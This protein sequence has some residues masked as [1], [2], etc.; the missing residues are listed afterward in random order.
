[1][2]TP[3]RCLLAALLLIASGAQ[4]ETPQLGRPLTA[5]QLA[6]LPRSVFPDG[7]GL[8][9]G[10]GTVADGRVIY[11]S[12][13]Q[14]CHGEQGRGG[15]GGQLISAGALTGPEPDPA[16]NNYWPYATTLWDYTRRAMPM[17]APGSLSVDDSYAVTAYLLHRSG[18]LAAD[19]GLDERSLPAL[20]MPNRDGFDW[21]D[22]RR[23]AASPPVSVGTGSGR[24]ATS[25]RTP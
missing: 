23:P 19:G 20:R 16:V 1:M 8:P 11:E 12:R 2:S 5:D 15:S 14:S 18:L 22:V 7:R 9:A 25:S 6:A 17:D 24:R 13:C 4:A 10:R 21:I 3:E